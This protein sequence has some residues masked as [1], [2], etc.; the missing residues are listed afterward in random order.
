[1]ATGAPAAPCALRLVCAKPIARRCRQHRPCPR[2]STA[3]SLPLSHALSPSHALKV[4][5]APRGSSARLALLRLLCVQATVR[6]LLE[7]GSAALP[8]SLE[9][10]I[11]PG[12]GGAGTD[13]VRPAASASHVLGLQV[14]HDKAHA[15]IHFCVPARTRAVCRPARDI[16]VRRPAARADAAAVHVHPVRQHVPTQLQRA[17][18]PLQPRNQH[19]RRR[20]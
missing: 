17:G 8:R 18:Q 13:F 3:Q 4:Q 15:R 10:R 5:T 16:P 7:T 20:S 2:A 1:M 12:I 6:S 9:S 11:W 19:V 14:R